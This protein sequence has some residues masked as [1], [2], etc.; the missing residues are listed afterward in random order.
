MK[1]PLQTIVEWE[2]RRQY[3][4]ESSFYTKVLNIT[5]QSW[6]RWKK[7]ER[8]LSDEKLTAVSKLFTPYEWMLIQKI[9]SDMRMYSNNFED[10]AVD[11]YHQSKIAVAKQWVSGDAKI[12]VNAARNVDDPDDGRISPGTTVKVTIEYDMPL[13]RKSDDL[14]FYTKESS[15]RIKA[16][17]ENRKKWFNKNVNELM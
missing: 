3:V 4:S 15:G 2:V 11:V 10:S 6:N 7:G 8:G 9:D 13:I 14:I 17:K 5:Q 12:N 1:K 16:G